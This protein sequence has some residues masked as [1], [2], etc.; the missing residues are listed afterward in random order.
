MLL[1]LVMLGV[2][3]SFHE[4][5][6]GIGAAFQ[7]RDTDDIQLT[8]VNE[9]I[10]SGAANGLDVVVS[11]GNTY[12]LAV[13]RA[14]QCL[15]AYNNSGVAAYTIP[16]GPVNVSCFGVA[17]N[18][19]PTSGSDTY[20]TSD[21]DAPSLFYTE[22]RGVTWTTETN[23]ASTSG[24]GLDFDGTYYW[25]ADYDQ[26]SDY[27]GVWRLQPGISSQSIPLSPVPPSYISGLTVFPYN[28][29]LCVAVTT[30][31]AHN[32]YFYLWNDSAMSYLGSAACPSEATVQY[33][34]GLAYSATSGTIFWSYLDMSN[35]FHIAELSFAIT[36]LEHSSWGSI[37]ASF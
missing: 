23:P 10:V 6:P 25:I 5:Y 36:E 1:S 2:A 3:F 30:Y 29:N 35:I 22:D 12:V 8:S 26:N 18:N 17:W 19:N 15:R 16:L 31:E 9:W 37:K 11:A 4:G 24:R 33:S 20:Y 14:A 7:H 34:L 27:N 28:N 21:W 32:I 13:D